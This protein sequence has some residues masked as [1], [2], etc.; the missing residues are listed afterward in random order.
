MTM[1][2][3]EIS[4]QYSAKPCCQLRFSTTQVIDAKADLS[5][6]YSH[7]NIGLDKMAR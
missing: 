2:R 5:V 3:D 4:P 6:I 1:A 7:F